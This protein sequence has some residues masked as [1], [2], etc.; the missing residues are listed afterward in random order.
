VKKFELDNV[1]VIFKQNPLLSFS[2]L[3]LIT[4][5]SLAL[6]SCGQKTPEDPIKHA[7]ELRMSGKADEAKVVLDEAIAID[8]TYAAAHYSRRIRHMPPR[9]MNYPERY[10]TWGLA[11]NK[12]QRII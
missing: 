9:I 10:F 1:A 12:K 11:K 5:I 6:L 2:P 3:I 7:Y 4:I 8:S